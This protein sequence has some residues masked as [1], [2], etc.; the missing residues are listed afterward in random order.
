MNIWDIGNKTPAFSICYIFDST[1]QER[2]FNFWV[3]ERGFK[4]GDDVLELGPRMILEI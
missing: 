2:P 1:G 4:E 3:L